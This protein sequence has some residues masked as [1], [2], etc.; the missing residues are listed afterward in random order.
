MGLYSGN[1]PAA[2]GR[3]E[4]K[5]IRD[6]GLRKMQSIKQTEL[7]LASAGKSVRGKYTCPLTALQ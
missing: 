3:S 7:C 4:K 6:M 2:A 5:N 1:L